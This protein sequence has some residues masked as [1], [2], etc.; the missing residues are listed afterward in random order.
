MAQMDHNDAVRLQAAEKYILGEFP[1][2]LRDEY[3][4]HFF[5]CAECAVDVKAIAAFADTTREVLRRAETDAAQKAAA[6]ARGGWF[7]WLRPIVAVPAFAVLL[8]VIGYQNT[9]TIP[10]KQGMAALDASQV[11]TSS[12]SLKKADTLGSEDA[13]SAEEGKIQV[14][15]DESF[16][17]QFDFTPR[18]AFDGYICQLQDESGRSLLQ[19]KIPGTSANRELHFV[20]PGGVVRP[21][22]YSLVLA[23]DPEASGRMTK[24]NEVSRL[25]FTVEFRP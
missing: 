2:N 7:A 24:T 3:E 11:F 9:V 23:G 25:P 17:L 12:F 13:K 16:A 6:P 14:R 22:K 18:Q 1:Q 5:D 4:E 8:L 10:R 21:A 19:V 20:V 15:P